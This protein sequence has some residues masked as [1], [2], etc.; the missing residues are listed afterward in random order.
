MGS[1]SGST[2]RAATRKASTAIRM[3]R[4]AASRFRARPWF[5]PRADQLVLLGCYR[6]L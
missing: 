2:N 5:G 4:G 3:L 1:W 6:P